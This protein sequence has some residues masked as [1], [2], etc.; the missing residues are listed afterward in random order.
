MAST[1]CCLPWRCSPEEIRAVAYPLDTPCAHEISSVRPE[2]RALEIGYRC[3]RYGQDVLAGEKGI[4]ILR[5]GALYQWAFLSARQLR[6]TLDGNLAHGRLIL[7]IMLDGVPGHCEGARVLNVNVHFQHG[8][9]FDSVEAFDDVKLLGVRRTES[10][11]RR[12]FIESDRI[13]DQRIAFVVADGFAIPGWLDVLGMLVREVDVANVI[14]ARQYHHHFLR[15]L[16]EIHR[17]GHGR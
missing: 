9:V 15:S 10:V 3:L 5:A 6:K 12:P 7:P 16:N 13:D 17:L 4:R 11:H 1:M 14:E 2:T 8:T